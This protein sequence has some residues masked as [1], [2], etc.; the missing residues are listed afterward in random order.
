MKLSN[1]P[2]RLKG[3]QQETMNATDENTRQRVRVLLVDD[4]EDEY[5]L[6]QGLLADRSTYAEGAE[7]A[8]F[9]LEWAETFEA[10]LIA[11]NHCEHDI[12]LID[13]N[14]GPRNGLELVEQA[15]A[16]GCQKPII[17][18]TGQG[19]YALD[20]QA[21]NAGVTDYLVKSEVTG[22][23]LERTIRYALERKRTETE[24]RKRAS[25]AQLLATLSQAFAAAQLD[26]IQVLETITHQVA[27]SIDDACIIHMLSEDN[28]A[29]VPASFHHPEAEISAALNTG[30]RLP[31]LSD[32]FDLFWK[33]V[34]S[35]QPLLLTDMPA[36]QEHWPW[37]AEK[38]VE[39]ALIMPLRVHGRAIGIMSTLRFS[40]QPPYSS[41]DQIFLQDLTDRAALAID[42]ARLYMA[43]AQRARELN[44]LHTATAALLSTIELEELLG[45][46]LDI[47]QS[48]IPATEKGMLYLLAPNTG[49]LE[50]RAT[51]G[52][53]DPRIRRITFP[54]GIDYPARVIQE[55][56]PLLIQDTL[57]ETTSEDPVPSGMYPIRSAV[58]APLILGEESLGV[59]SLSTS[60]PGAFSEADLRL[61][62]SF[63]TTTTAAIQNAMLHAEVQK[64]ALSDSLTELYNRRGFFE[65]GQRE[66]ERAHR[67]DRPLSAIMI[68]LDHLKDINDTYGHAA[69][70][71]VIQTLATR[72]RYSLRE[73]DIIGR[74]GGDEFVILLPETD[75]F[76]ACT[77]AE[78]I[79]SHAAE[80]IQLPASADLSASIQITISIGV[81]NTVPETSDLAALL[82]RAD[83]AAYRA[84]HGGRNRVEVG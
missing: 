30:L 31:E 37:A 39:C 17:L 77:V 12:Y 47:A 63:A 81:A 46:I 54:R 80:A 79:R 72:L 27:E 3:K 76:T 50:I 49:K 22:P 60:H 73:V 9:D 48:A 28:R 42:N 84:K 13:Y 25:Q 66:I 51:T 45:H 29:L 7:Q 35:G 32:Q 18:M 21:M 4:D 1:C 16:L 67:F 56:K 83:A 15:E 33:V 69:G 82:E 59:L 78:R 10:A 62:V 58:I 43:Q 75:L 14:L 23:L 5:I 11:I 53:K 64:L 40:A 2:P 68:D 19:S 44:A 52:Y 26:Y 71:Y 36:I 74:Y 6:T 65:L 61:L 57:S 41:D 24:I 70:D 38:R 55:R 34:R 8:G 20:L